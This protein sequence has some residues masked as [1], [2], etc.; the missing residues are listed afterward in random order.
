MCT[1]ANALKPAAWRCWMCNLGYLAVGVSVHTPVI[2][3][4][5]DEMDMCNCAARLY[6]KHTHKILSFF[7]S[8]R[9]LRAVTV[10]QTRTYRKTIYAM[11]G[12]YCAIKNVIISSLSLSDACETMCRWRY[13]VKIHISYICAYMRDDGCVWPQRCNRS[14]Q[15][16]WYFT[17]LSNQIVI[18]KWKP[19]WCLC[20]RFIGTFYNRL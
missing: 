15:D 17:Y 2:Y 16:A 20:G 4:V 18:N 8:Y 19:V 7:S 13:F 10:M 12:L 3:L 14:P 1:R 9:D 6:S 11:R 5:A